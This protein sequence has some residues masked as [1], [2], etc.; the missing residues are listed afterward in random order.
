MYIRFRESRS[1]SSWGGS[2]NSTAFSPWELVSLLFS[3]G[4]L[5]FHPKVSEYSWPLRKVCSNLMDPHTRRVFSINNA[6]LHDEWVVDAVAAEPWGWRADLRTWASV[7]LGIYGESWNQPPAA[8]EQRL[9]PEVHIQL[10]DTGLKKII[11]FL[12]YFSVNLSANFY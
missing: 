12:C 6:G 10:E 1:H 4:V 5:H 9:V 3:A 11:I 8:I 2:W 7:D